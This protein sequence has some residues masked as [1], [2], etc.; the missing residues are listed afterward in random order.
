MKQDE[1][2]QPKTAPQENELGV[3]PVKSL[4]VKLAVP[5]IAAQIVNVLY[6][7]VDRMYIGHIPDT[8]ALSLTGVGVCMPLIML[9]SAFAALASMG[10]APR[11]SI[12]LGK[13][14]K[15]EAERTL[16]NCTMLLIIL[17]ITLTLILMFYSE[18]LLLAFGASENTIGYALD[19]MNI[20]ALGTIFVQLALGLNAF[21][22]A[23]GFAKVSMQTILIG[24]ISNIILDPIFIFFLGMGVKGAALATIISQGI[25]A[26]WVVMFLTG[27]GTTLKLRLKNF[28]IHGK[29][30]WPCVLLGLSPFIM[31]STESIISICFNSS[32]LKYGGDTAVGAMTILSSVMQFSMLPLVGL[33]Q[34]AQPITGYNF[35][36]KKPERVKEGFHLLLKSSLLY[37]MALWAIVMLFPRVVSSMFASDAALLDY[38][39]WAMRYYMLFSGIFGIQIACQQTF[40]AIGNA[41][42]SLFLAILRKI[43]LL[44]PFIYILPMFIE[45]K[46]KAV[47]LAEPAADL[48][49]VATTAILFMVQFKKAMKKLEEEKATA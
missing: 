40:I 34:G 35:G 32:L 49:A 44:I 20:Y 17:A 19:Y 21:I 3:L 45:D 12:L 27:N 7:V 37:S 36:A 24:A 14:G 28:K 38:S 47:F 16:G 13:G 23:Q 25:S 9:I 11:S 48:I 18:P 4:L 46:A 10:G 39:A 29:T 22:T 26:V 30:L 31:Q 42:T 33:A 8:G 6:N 15:E 2:N 1:I 5:A 41:K 43:L